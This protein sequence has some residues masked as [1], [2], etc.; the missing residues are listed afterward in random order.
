MQQPPELLWNRVGATPTIP[1]S[2]PA[3]GNTTPTNGTDAHL[4]ALAATGDEVPRDQTWGEGT[5]KPRRRVAI[6]PT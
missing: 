4:H 5:P 6:E 3:Q 2:S 1:E